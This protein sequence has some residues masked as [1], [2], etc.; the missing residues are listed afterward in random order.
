MNWSL[1]VETLLLLVMGVWTVA[2]VLAGITAVGLELAM[3]GQAR[4]GREWTALRF[5]A[6]NKSHPIGVLATL[7]AAV[8]TGA[9]A[10]SSLNWAGIAWAIA[11]GTVI[12]LVVY[13]VAFVSLLR[14]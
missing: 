14:G 2:G 4:F 12:D 5:A 13:V 1:I 11:I 6:G 3:T 8:A 9:F 10:G 7:I